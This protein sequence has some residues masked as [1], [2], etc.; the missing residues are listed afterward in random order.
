MFLL[1]KVKGVKALSIHFRLKELI[2]LLIKPT[3]KV[4]IVIR[5]IT[6]SD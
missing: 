1:R 6:I 4:E 5:F 3:I 2:S